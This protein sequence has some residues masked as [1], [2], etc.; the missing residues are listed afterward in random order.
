MFEEV[1]LKDSYLNTVE[2]GMS[3]LNLGLQHVSI[4]R[5]VMPNW[6]EKRVQSAS[7]MKEIC[8]AAIKFDKEK[9]TAITPSKT[10]ASTLV[11]MIGV[12]E[13]EVMTNEAIGVNVRS[14]HSRR[15]DQFEH[16]DLR[17]EWGKAMQH[18]IGVIG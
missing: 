13:D 17:V 6:A 11:G 4:K 9:A 8:A 15:A 1:V 12:S 18:P 10:A 7:T 2:R 3:I 16:R 14:D 5:G